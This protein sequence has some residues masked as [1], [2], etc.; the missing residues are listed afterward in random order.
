M[1]FIRSCT[2]AV[3]L[4]SLFALT[5]CG[6]ES[7][8]ADDSE[9]TTGGTSNSGTV[10]EG[11]STGQTSAVGGA[12]EEGGEGGEGE[13]G[14]GGTSSSQGGA[15]EPGAGGTSSGCTDTVSATAAVE[16]QYSGLNLYVDGRQKSYRFH[17]N[18]W[19]EF[20]E[21]T[22]DIEGLGFTVN[23]PNG[24]A[25]PQTDGAPAGYPSLYIGTYSGVTTDGSNLPIRVTDIESVETIMATN[26][27]ELDTSNINASYDVWLTESGEPLPTEQYNP[28]RGGAYLMVWLFD[29]RDRQPR[30]GNC[31]GSG[32]VA[33]FPART[34]PGADGVWDVWVD[35]TDPP[36]ISYVSTTPLSSY[37]FDLK[38]FIDDSVT[39]SYGVTNS[40]YLSVV[41]GGFEIWG[42][43]DGLTMENFCAEVRPTSP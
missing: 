19:H 31:S 38:A 42:G 14:A 39:E 28:G 29:P 35:N 25:V 37:A 8:N 27:L 3:A 2:K 16:G 21:Q 20:N 30:G 43:G 10:T 36:C 7:S 18:W 26:S 34:I 23:D 15:S 6:G 41:F 40:M 4:S 13:P 24:T 9:S 17:T 32:C 11:G 5:A 22:I 1:L 33:D 12:I